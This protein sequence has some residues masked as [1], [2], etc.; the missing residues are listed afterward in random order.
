L[1]VQG[2]ADEVVGQ[3]HIST[4]RATGHGVT[5]AA[6]LLKDAPGI[7]SVAAFGQALHVSGTDREAV[8]RAL[9]PLQQRDDLTIEET[10]PTLEDVFIHLL[11]SSG[12]PAGESA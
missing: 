2:S 1:I 7:D 8:V 4:W 12:A 6:Q 5:Q 3:A 10:E 9:Q 11:A